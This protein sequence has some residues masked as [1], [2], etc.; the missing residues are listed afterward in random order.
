[1]KSEDK[2]IK[3]LVLGFGGSYFVESTYGWH[4][5]NLRGNYP[6]LQEYVNKHKFSNVEV[7][8]SQRL[9]TIALSQYAPLRF[10]STTQQPRITLELANVFQSLS[11]SPFNDHHYLMVFKNGHGRWSL[12]SEWASDIRQV[13]MQYHNSNATTNGST[14]QSSNKPQPHPHSSPHPTNSHS[15]GRPQMQHHHSSAEDVKEWMDVGLTGV[16]V[17]TAL[18]TVAVGAGCSVM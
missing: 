1:M 16:K 2:R 10:S 7:R 17:A 12:P 5:W 11:L 6:N 8:A 13:A 9:P 15:G 4:A 18:G 14:G 3:T